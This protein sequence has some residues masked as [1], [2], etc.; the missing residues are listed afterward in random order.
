MPVPAAL[1]DDGRK[2]GREGDVFEARI[3][4]PLEMSEYS[5]P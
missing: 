2:A 1:L 5:E 4:R 3:F